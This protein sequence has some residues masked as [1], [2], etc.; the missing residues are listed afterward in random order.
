MI[1]KEFA[2][3]DHLIVKEGLKFLCVKFQNNLFRE[4]G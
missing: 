2:I 3:L 1:D 4:T